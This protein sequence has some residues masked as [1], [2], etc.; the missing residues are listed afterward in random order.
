M[1]AYISSSSSCY[2]EQAKQKL[3]LFHRLEGRG[4]N[5][6][7]KQNTGFS[8]WKNPPCSLAV[9]PLDLDLDLDPDPDPDPSAAL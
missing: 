8:R 4:V 6:E 5:S 2:L 1:C 3:L 7:K 9:P